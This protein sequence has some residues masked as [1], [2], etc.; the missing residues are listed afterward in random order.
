MQ[1][2]RTIDELNWALNIYTDIVK[3]GDK[4]QLLKESEDCVKVLEDFEEYEKCFDIHQILLNK[5]APV[6]P[7]QKK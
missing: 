1:T 7:R 5:K 6:F 4:S 2:L 3:Y